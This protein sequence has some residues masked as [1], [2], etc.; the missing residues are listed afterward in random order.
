[1]QKLKLGM[2]ITIAAWAA[3]LGAP[4]LNAQYASPPNAYSATVINSMFGGP[5]TLQIHRDGNRAVVDHITPAPAGGKESRSRSYY[6]LQSHKNVS[7]SLGEDVSGCGSGTFS[8]SWGDPF[9]DSADTTKEIADKHLTPTG[10]ETVNGFA[11]K[12]MEFSEPGPIKVKAWVDDQ[13]GLVVKLQMTGADGKTQTLL[14]VTKLSVAP[15][16]ASVFTIPVACAGALSA[17]TEAERLATVTGDKAENF[18]NAIMGPGSKASC[19]VAL[20]IVKAGSM[21]PVTSGI[22]VAVDRSVDLQHPASYQTGISK[23]GHYTYSG[24]GIQELTAQMR[25]GVLRMD[26]VPAQMQVD[27]AFG[28]GG[29]ASALI[30][31]QCVAPVTVLMLVVKNPRNLSDGP[32]DWLWVKSGKYAT[33]PGGN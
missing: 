22:Q 21:E 33:V 15:P 26:N 29:D 27:V 20:R 6:D 16:A 19:S 31:R 8:G 2:W 9:E 11:T 1:M 30:Y 13:Y 28:N 25:N 17:P 10:A 32:A 18:A 5:V 24:G 12:I 3:H 7:W 4:R 14:E 23:E